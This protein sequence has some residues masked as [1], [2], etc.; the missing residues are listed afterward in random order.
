MPGLEGMIAFGFNTGRALGKLS[1]M[2][3][4]AVLINVSALS[5]RAFRRRVKVG[6]GV[7]ARSIKPFERGRLGLRQTRLLCQFNR[8]NERCEGV[9][10]LC[11]E[12][13][14]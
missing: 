3:G 7:R 13:R 4:R 6:G 10:R 8:G 12:P 5:R 2:T 9:P 1:L 11:A 14:R